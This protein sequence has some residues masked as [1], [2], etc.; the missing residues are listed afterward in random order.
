MGESAC[1]G[2]MDGA[3]R[4]IQEKMRALRHQ[5]EHRIGKTTADHSTILAW[6]AKWAT[7]F[8]SKYALRDDNTT[9]YERVRR[10]TCQ[11]PL[12]PFGEMAMYLPMKTPTANKVTPT[13]KAGIWLGV[14]ERIE[15]AIIGTRDGVAKC[16]TINKSAKRGAMEQ[17]HGTSNEKITMGTDSWQEECAHTA[18]YRWRRRKP[19]KRSWMWNQ[20]HNRF[21]WR[22]PNGTT[23]QHW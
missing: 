5:L 21:G 20:T 23:W 11:V 8:L 19:R 22:C 4:R 3:V 13:K 6:M 16:K 17:R 2:R 9:P 1:N 12:V 7:K 15:E 18:G 10:D 14:I